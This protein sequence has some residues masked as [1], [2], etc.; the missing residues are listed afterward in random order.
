VNEERP[1][2]YAR[3]TGFFAFEDKVRAE[4]FSS[5]NLFLLWRT[6]NSDFTRVSSGFYPTLERFGPRHFAVLVFLDAILKALL[7]GNCLSLSGAFVARFSAYLADASKE[8]A[9]NVCR[10]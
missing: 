10:K 8:F 2:F 9:M 1:R 3:T 6:F 4:H 7:F 5:E